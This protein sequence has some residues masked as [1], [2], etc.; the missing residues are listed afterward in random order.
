MWLVFK[1]EKIK[2]GESGGW[3]LQQPWKGN[4]SDLRP[5]GYCSQSPLASIGSCPD[6][7]FTTKSFN[8]NFPLYVDISKG[9]IAL[10]L[11]ILGFLAV[12]FHILNNCLDFKPILHTFWFWLTWDKP[13][14]IYHLSLLLKFETSGTTPLRTKPI[15]WSPNQNTAC[16]LN[17]WLSKYNRYTSSRFF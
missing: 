1:Y 16:Y 17:T 9:M 10:I 5:S 2:K 3:F 13:Q 12:T 14:S 4:P 15:L 11:N 6:C 7:I 8:Y